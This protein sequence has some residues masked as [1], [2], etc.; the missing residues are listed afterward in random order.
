MFDR[1]HQ[2]IIIVA[3]IFIMIFSTIFAVNTLI[4]IISI[5]ILSPA[6]YRVLLIVKKRIFKEEQ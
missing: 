1:K 6:I 3:I 4:E 2:I 5:S